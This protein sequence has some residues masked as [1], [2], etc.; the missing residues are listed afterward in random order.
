M[1]KVFPVFKFIYTQEIKLFLS[2][3]WEEACS[4]LRLACCIHVEYCLLCSVSGLTQ[5]KR[6]LQRTSF[7]ANWKYCF[8]IGYHTLVPPALIV[9]FSSSML[10][11]TDVYSDAY[12][13]VV[14]ITC[15]VPIAVVFVYACVYVAHSM[16]R[17][18]TTVQN[19]SPH[20][21]RKLVSFLS[22]LNL[23]QEETMTCI[24]EG[25]PNIILD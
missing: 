3:I 7:I 6:I 25:G 4:I 8:A 23:V 20:I 12:H 11:F 21:N 22:L 9:V 15:L 5:F 16:K 18:T 1:K 2:Q 13:I 14:C 10:I 17:E 19:V 24:L